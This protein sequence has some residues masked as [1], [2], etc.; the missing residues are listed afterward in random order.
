MDELLRLP[1]IDEVRLLVHPVIVGAGK[2][3]FESAPETRFELSET[4]ATATG[5]VVSTYRPVL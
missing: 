2:R 4:V 5:V 3:L 1:A